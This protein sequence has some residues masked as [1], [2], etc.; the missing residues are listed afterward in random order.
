LPFTS[1]IAPVSDG[2]LMSSYREGCPVGPAD[3]RLV[4]LTY[5]GFDESPHTGEL[6]IAA[7]Y[8]SDVV[9]VFRQLYE[10][11]FP[12]RRMELVEALGG[13]DEASMAAD[14]TSAFNC[15]QVAGT[16]RWSEHAYGRAIDVNPVEN[17]HVTRGVAEPTAGAAFTNRADVRPG[18]IVAGDVATRA[19]AAIGWSWGGA[20][21]SSKDYQHFSATGR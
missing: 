15:R 17:P 11:R 7:Q 18:M 2:L 13:S 4:T 20:W 9:G 10:A 6:V 3:L 12:I 19:F 1:S 5:W 16:A 8:A 14:N 21:Q